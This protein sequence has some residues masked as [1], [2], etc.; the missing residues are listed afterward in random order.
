MGSKFAHDEAER[1]GP[2]PVSAHER[3]THT[4]QAF[5]GTPDSEFAVVATS[6]VYGEG[7]K[8]GLTWGDLRALLAALPERA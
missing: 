1:L 8:T 5:E 4:V 3:L 7:V 2:E 6:G